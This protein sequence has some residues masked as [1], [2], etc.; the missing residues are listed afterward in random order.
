MRGDR[1]RLC[2]HNWHKW[3]PCAPAP[4]HRRGDD[5][6]A[7][8]AAVVDTGMWRHLRRK[9]PAAAA[10]RLVLRHNV[11]I[12]SQGLGRPE[13]ED[14]QYRSHRSLHLLSR[15]RGCM[16]LPLRHD[17][18]DRQYGHVATG[19][20]HR[21]V[22][23]DSGGQDGFRSSIRSW[24]ARPTRASLRLRL[25]VIGITPLT[26][27][28]PFP[29]YPA[30]EASRPTRFPRPAATAVDSPTTGSAGGGPEGAGHDLAPALSNLI[31]DTPRLRKCRFIPC[32]QSLIRDAP[33]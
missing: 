12:G 7:E 11:W 18:T 15:H 16:T 21:S 20:C 24:K 28:R 5:V 29:I 4:R 22:R 8:I 17:L 6:L 33:K 30:E 3:R 27:N 31:F 26:G 1:A 14:R 13:H 2:F 25:Q 10:E 32:F 23:S 9:P 19:R